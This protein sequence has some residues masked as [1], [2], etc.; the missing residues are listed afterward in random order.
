M[1]RGALAILTVALLLSMLFVGCSTGTDKVKCIDIRLT[2]EQYAFGV[3][4]SDTELLAVANQLLSQLKSNGELE[5]IINKYF[6]NDTS[7]IKTFGAGVE[8]KKQKSACCGYAYSIF[9]L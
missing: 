6:S 4:K 7:S 1:R 9:T 2:S 8:A 3:N 5:N